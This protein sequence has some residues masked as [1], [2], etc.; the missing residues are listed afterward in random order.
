MNYSEEVKCEVCSKKSALISKALKV[1]KDCIL[2]R[3]EKALPYIKK[4]HE[5]SRIKHSL[6]PYPPLNGEVECKICANQCKI[7]EGGKGFCGLTSSPP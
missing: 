1:C 4:I 3:F 2:D 7:P 6:P 5:E